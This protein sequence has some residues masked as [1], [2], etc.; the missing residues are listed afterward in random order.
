LVF[1]FVDV[2]A[3]VSVSWVLAAV[4]ASSVSAALCLRLWYFLADV[5]ASAVVAVGCAA[6]LAASA[7]LTAASRASVVS[8]TGSAELA[9]EGLGAGPIAAPTATPMPS[10]AAASAAVTRADGARQGDF[11]LLGVLFIVW[12]GNIVNQEHGPDPSGSGPCP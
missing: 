9:C 11:S 5:L 2:G 3:V 1:G 6:A 8:S 4:D 7:A 12:S 10:V